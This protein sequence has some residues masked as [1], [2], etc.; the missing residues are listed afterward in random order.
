M[1]KDPEETTPHSKELLPLHFGK[2]GFTLD[3]PATIKQEETKARHKPG[4]RL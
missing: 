4:F 2:M 3:T 1:G